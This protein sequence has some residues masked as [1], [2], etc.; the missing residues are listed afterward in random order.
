MTTKNEPKFKA[1]D[2]IRYRGRVVDHVDYRVDYVSETGGV[3]LSWIEDDERSEVFLRKE[4]LSKYELAPEKKNIQETWSS[5]DLQKP[6][7]I[8]MDDFL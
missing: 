7:C 8:A 1:G 5:S 2:V 6:R 3:V 4:A